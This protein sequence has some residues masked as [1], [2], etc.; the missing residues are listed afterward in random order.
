M[1]EPYCREF[2]VGRREIRGCRANCR[3]RISGF[4]AC[5]IKVVAQIVACT[6][7]SY[8]SSWMNGAFVSADSSRVITV[9]GYTSV[10]VN[11]NHFEALIGCSWPP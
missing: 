10:Y 9:V 5:L 11:K 8:A 6:S 3:Y 7:N 2:A 1:A 4:A